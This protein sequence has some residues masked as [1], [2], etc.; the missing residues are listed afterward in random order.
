MLLLTIRASKPSSG[1][2]TRWRRDSCSN[3]KPWTW[4]WPQICS[5]TFC[6]TSAQR[7]PL[8]LRNIDIPAPGEHQVLLRVHACGVCR[9]DLHILDGD[10]PDPKL[11]LVLGHEIVATVQAAGADAHQFQPAERVGV[12]WLGWT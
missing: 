4:W 9:T 11:P 8:Q 7:T 3:P 10:L 2:W 5:P 6:Q 12:P 1:W